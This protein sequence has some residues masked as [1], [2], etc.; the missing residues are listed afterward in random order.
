[1]KMKNQKVV[2][3]IESDTRF[4]LG[5]LAITRAAMEAVEITEAVAALARHV[6]GDWGTVCQENWE[7]NNRALKHGGGLLST[8]CED[9]TVF[10]IITEWDRSATTILLPSDN[11]DAKTKLMMNRPH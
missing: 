1:M 10:W 3:T 8:Y 2:L 6:V 7:L 9:Q 11:Q 5:R 4:P